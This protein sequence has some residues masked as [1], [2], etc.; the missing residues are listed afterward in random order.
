M[1]KGPKQI[2]EVIERAV[3]GLR[4]LAPDTKFNNT[5]LA[6]L[7]PLAEESLAARRELVEIG[8]LEAAGIARREAADARVL[9]MIEKIVNGIIGDENFGDDSAL[10][11]AFGF[12]RR[13]QRKSGLTRKRKS[14]VKE[15]K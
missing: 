13:S 2:E 14:E 8:N 4:D 6:D 11:E 1:G 10:Y 7:T 5:N 9:K 12:V 15:M 3:N